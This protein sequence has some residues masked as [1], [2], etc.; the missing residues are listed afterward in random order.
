MSHPSRVRGLKR[1]SGKAAGRQ[2]AVAPFTGAWIETAPG[3]RHH[4]LDTSHPSRV[5]GLKLFGR[6]RRNIRR[7]SHPSRVRGLKHL[8]VSAATKGRWVAPFTGA[9]IET[10]K[11]MSVA[12]N[13]V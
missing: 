6:F 12:P 2:E 10:S 4:P 1:Q 13:T 8:R 9:W 7:W 5:R 11:E 3:K